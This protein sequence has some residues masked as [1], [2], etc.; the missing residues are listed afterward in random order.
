MGIPFSDVDPERELKL[1]LYYPI[2]FQTVLLDHAFS[3]IL[4]GISL[5]LCTVKKIQG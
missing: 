3:L 5:C 1:K 4:K 2:L